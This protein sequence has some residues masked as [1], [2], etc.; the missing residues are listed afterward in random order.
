MTYLVGQII[1]CL[2]LAALIGAVTAWWAR[3]RAG[4]VR[5][6]VEAD[7]QNRMHVIESERDRYREQMLE[8]QSKARTADA[9]AE[10]LRRGRAA[11]EN[12]LLEKDG[13]IGALEQERVAHAADATSLLRSREASVASQEQLST[14]RAQLTDHDARRDALSQTEQALQ[15]TQA[16]VDALSHERAGLM[17]NVVD[18][19]RAS[20][21]EGHRLRAAIESERA[22]VPSLQADVARLK[23]LVEVRDARIREQEGAASSLEKQLAESESVGA[24]RSAEI[25]RVNDA[26]TS[27]ET[28]RMALDL[29][30]VERERTIGR[31]EADVAKLGEDRLRD[32]MQFRHDRDAAIGAEQK[33]ATDWR[34]RAGALQVHLKERDGLVESLQRKLKEQGARLEA[35]EADLSQC[36]ADRAKAQESV[37][38]LLL[39]KPPQEVDDLQEIVGVGPVLERALH[40]LGIHLFRQIAALRDADVEWLATNLKSFPDRIRRQQWIRQAGDLQRRK[41]GVPTSS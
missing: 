41:Y 23:K 4:E 10:G 8:A 13:R 37:G 29:A 26:L 33:A 27:L 14:L 9:E 30:L 7:W 20:E 28:K 22:V 39:T 17:S 2:G 36:Q 12:A 34:N 1:L 15:Q 25:E 19:E 3:S 31:L 16:R 32:E 24:S 6:A 40:R 18:L 11:N 38:S 21:A 35:I 5:A